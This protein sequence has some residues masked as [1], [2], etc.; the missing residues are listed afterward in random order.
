MASAGELAVAAKLVEYVPTIPLLAALLLAGCP[1]PNLYTTPR[2]LDPGKVQWQVAPEFIVVNHAPIAQDLLVPNA[3]NETS[4]SPMPPSWGV[5]IG[6]LNGFEI[7]A[8]EQNWD[9]LAVDAKIRLFK[10]RELDVALDPGVQAVLSRDGLPLYFHA[11]VLLGINFSENFSIVLS[12]GF[13]YTGAT[14]GLTGAGNGTELATTV[15]GPMGA[16]GLGFD[17]R[18]SHRFAIHPEVTFVKPFDM[19]LL[20]AVVGIGF[21]IGGQ[22]DYSDL[23]D[24]PEAPAAPVQPPA[25][26]VS[27]PP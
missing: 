20:M 3:Q 26:P 19:N 23:A 16:M 4:S 25:A 5:R 11:P 21:N 10:S 6:V 15:T 1:N 9:A 17:F 14:G 12:P 18:I 24:A 8:R 13:A 27:A 22:P 2:T 7:G